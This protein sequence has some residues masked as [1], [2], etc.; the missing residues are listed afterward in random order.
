MRLR[1]CLKHLKPFVCISNCLSRT[2][3]GHSVKHVAFGLRQ[4]R[5]ERAPQPETGLGAREPLWLPCGQPR[6]Q[7]RTL[8]RYAVHWGVSELA[9]S[10]A[11]QFT[12]TVTHVRATS[13]LHQTRARAVSVDQQT[14]CC[15]DLSSAPKHWFTVA[16][17]EHSCRTARFVKRV[18]VHTVLPVVGSLLLSSV[19]LRL[20]SLSFVDHS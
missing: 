15:F 10:S 7:L 18:C 20:L 2:F 4:D 6:A 3:K 17:R 11:M 16:L 9:H 8:V 13:T 1:Q 5:E 12:P 19:M 14:I